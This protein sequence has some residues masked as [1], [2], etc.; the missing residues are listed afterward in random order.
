LPRASKTSALVLG[1]VTDRL[2]PPPELAATEAAIFRATVASVAPG[3]F[4]PEDVALLSAYARAAVLERRAF[5]QANAAA[6]AH[7]AKSLAALSV[8]LRIGLRSR[9]PS[10][11]RRRSA[12]SAPV[13][14]Y[15]TM[16]LGDANAP[17]RPRS[18][19][20]GNGDGQG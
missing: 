10:N 1:P 9:A 2:Q 6:H 7:A 3:H 5:E 8:R 11:N 16:N 19:D 15:E 12:K 17:D 18:P 13:S 20:A 4:A 14:Y